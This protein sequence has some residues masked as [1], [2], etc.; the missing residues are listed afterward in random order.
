MTNDLISR[1]AAITTVS[2]AMADSP[3]ITRDDWDAIIE[4]L[5]CVPSEQPE[6]IK[7]KDCV[8]WTKQNDS[9]QGR[10]E[11]YGFYP[12]GYYYCAGAKERGIHE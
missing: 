9:L 10:C 4:V 5:E 8:N 6:I 1:Q 3:S 7:C 12:T 11:K 2:F